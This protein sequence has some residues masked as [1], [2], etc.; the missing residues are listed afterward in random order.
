MAAK[1]KKKSKPELVIDRI[2][3][4]ASINDKGIL[5]FAGFEFF[6]YEAALHA[7]IDF[8]ENISFKTKKELRDKSLRACLRNG[9]L[10]AKDFIN[11]I[12]KEISIYKQKQDSVFVLTT[13]VSLSGG[14]PISKIVL[15]DAVVQS[16]SKGLPKKYKNRSAHDNKWLEL[17][18]DSPLPPLYSHVAVRV[19]AKRPS[20]A[21]DIAVNS[22]DFIRGVVG[23][24]VNSSYQISLGTG[25]S[26]PLNKVMLGGMHCLHFEN[27]ELVFPDFFWYERHY[28]ERSVTD[29][30]E[31]RKYIA[32]G[33][34]F[35][36]GSLSKYPKEDFDLL[37]NAI[38][39]YARAFDEYDRDVL[40]QKMWAALESIVASGENNADVIVRRCSY[41]YSD[42][43]Y[44]SQVLE[45]IRDYRNQNVHRGHSEEGLDHYCFELQKFFRELV[46]FYARFSRLFTSLS[47]ANRFLDCSDNERKLEREIEILTRAKK[48]RFG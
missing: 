38:A 34:R 26:K 29:I 41:L 8:G 11:T 16:Y 9:S 21:F 19:N 1:W 47:E 30:N 3:K 46:I 40:I 15:P 4:H 14:L 5:S 39:R 20:D 23:L 25:L 44:A 27:G 10:T 32:K 12:N 18:S 13:S 45:Y 7:I 33:C 28:K 24:N 42:R 43:E 31:R 37:R 36:L 48:F 35:L 22:L 2:K 6:Q 17:F